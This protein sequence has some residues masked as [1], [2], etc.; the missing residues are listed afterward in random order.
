VSAYRHATHLDLSAG[1]ARCQ[2]PAVGDLV[3]VFRGDRREPLS[4]D[5]ADY[6]L[7]DWLERD[8]APFAGRDLK[9]N[10]KRARPESSEAFIT[11]PERLILVEILAKVEQLPEKRLPERMTNE[12][13]RILKT[14]R[15][16]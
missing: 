4:D 11:E 14:A 3:L 16:P 15:E 9:R 8:P 12:F 13:S 6:L 5:G 10:I 7:T 1:I 2:T